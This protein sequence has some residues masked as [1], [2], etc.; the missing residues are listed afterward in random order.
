LSAAAAA[1]QRSRFEKPSF[2]TA[3]PPSTGAG[4]TASTFS[5]PPPTSGLS[6]LSQDMDIDMLDFSSAGRTPVQQHHYQ[7]PHQHQNHHHHHQQQQQ[8]QPPP[9]PAAA[10]PAHHSLA[11]GAANETGSQEWEW[12][13]MSL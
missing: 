10:N 1:R 11:G 5:S 13:T 6:P 2:T 7:Q 8:P 3:A 4:V 12:L 9:Q